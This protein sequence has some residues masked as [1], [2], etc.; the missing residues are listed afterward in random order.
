MHE[1]TCKQGA[2]VPGAVCLLLGCLS[3]GVACVGMQENAACPTAW[4]CRT[5]QLSVD[6]SCMLIT[7]IQYI[8]SVQQQDALDLCETCVLDEAACCRCAAAVEVSLCCCTC[9]CKPLLTL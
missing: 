8:V 1:Q 5:V 3:V 6:A 4:P 9:A 2:P 7:S